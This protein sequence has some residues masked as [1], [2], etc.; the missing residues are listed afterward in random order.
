MSGQ[1]VA[2]T[3]MRVC[4]TAYSALAVGFTLYLSLALLFDY[5]KVWYLKKTANT[6]YHSSQFCN[7]TFLPFPVLVSNKSIAHPGF[8]TISGVL[9]YYLYYY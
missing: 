2:R 6:P 8:L 9:S 1:T 3:V 5:K 4:E 7:Q